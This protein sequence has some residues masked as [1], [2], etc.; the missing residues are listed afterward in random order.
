MIEFTL[1]FLLAPIPH[2]G[3]SQPVPITRS[4]APIGTTPTAAVIQPPRYRGMRIPR[5]MALWA[6]VFNPGPD[7]DAPNIG[8]QGGWY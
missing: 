4:A 3:E 1:P 6:A 8:V 7:H 5:G 2:A